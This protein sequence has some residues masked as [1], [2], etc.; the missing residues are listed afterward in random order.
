MP[1]HA[2]PDI[3]EVEHKGICSVD[4]EPWPCLHSR[5]E[6]HFEFS[7]WYNALCLACG[8]QASAWTVLTIDR[9]LEGRR[10]YFHDRKRCRPAAEKWWNEHVKP[11]TGE[12]FRP[13]QSITDLHR[14]VGARMKPQIV[15][16]TS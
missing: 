10:I 3:A 6:T 15:S 9:D 1:L 5:R 12:N 8:K 13:H 16:K 11:I 7:R 4:G 14:Y 2:V